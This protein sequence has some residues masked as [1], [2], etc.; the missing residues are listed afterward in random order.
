MVL[1]Y[2]CGYPNGSYTGWYVA[3][4]RRSSAD[5]RPF[6]DRYLVL[7][8]G[9]GAD[10]AA[11]SDTDVTTY[12]S[13]RVDIHVVADHAIMRYRRMNIQNAMSPNRG[14]SGDDCP[15]SETG[16]FSDLHFVSDKS[17]RML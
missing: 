9:A 15:R 6:S 17:T 10:I 5:H 1:D 3:N 11:F 2:P 12:G 16:T 7:D 13:A 14:T 8:R 4:H